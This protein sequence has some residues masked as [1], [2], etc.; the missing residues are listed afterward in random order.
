M[1]IETVPLLRE[2]SVCWWEIESAFKTLPAGATW[3]AFGRV[4][5]W[6][7]LGPVNNLFRDAIAGAGRQA[8]AIGRAGLSYPPKTLGPWQIHDPVSVGF[9][10]GQEVSAPV[11]IGGGYYRHTATP[12]VNGRLPSMGVQMYDYKAG[13]RV[14]GTTYLGVLMPKVSVRGEAVDE[15]GEGGRVMFAP[16]LMPHD[17]DTAAAA[18]AGTLPTTTPYKYSH[19]QLTLN[20]DLDWR[21]HS[22]EFMLDNFAKHNYY[23]NSSYGEKP[24]EAPPE[25]AKSDARFDIIADGHSAGGI[26]RDLKN[27]ATKFNGQIK[28]VRT[29]NQDEWAIN[30]TDVIIE[31]APQRRSRGKNHYDLQCAVRAS[32][33]EWVDQ[34]ST[35]FFPA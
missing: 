5:E 8:N 17:H 23:H 9:A 21:L 18:K 11:A 25:G 31:D 4:D 27:N 29:A 3:R 20:A 32:S 19:V 16:T 12:T 2:D 35:R 30:L 10:W 22:W 26:L 28:C 6:T 7:D 34:L 24:A 1:A 13:T 33:F 14:D 15:G